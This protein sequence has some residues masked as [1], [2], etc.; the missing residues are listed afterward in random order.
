MKLYTDGA[1]KGNP[2]PASIGVTVCDDKE[3]VV[4]EYSAPIGEATNNVAEYKALIKGLEMCSPYDSVEHYSDSK[5]LI[6]QVNGEWKIKDRNIL[7]LA[8]RIWELEKSFTKVTHQW[9][10][11]HHRMIKRTDKIASEDM[12]AVMCFCGSVLTFEESDGKMFSTCECGR[13]WT[14]EKF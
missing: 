12:N 11:R 6:N 7:S 5:L 13:L 1:S 3:K 2:G 14:V 10:P 8:E 4:D 9:V